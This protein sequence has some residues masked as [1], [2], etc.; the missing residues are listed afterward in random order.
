MNCPNCGAPLHLQGRKDSFTCEYCR[1]IYFPEENDDG[2]R[3]LGE[4][5]S[6]LCPVC[7]IPLTHA[8]MEHHRIQYCT[9]CRGTLVEMSVFIVLIDDLRAERGGFAEVQPPPEPQE[10]KRHLRCPHCGRAMDTHFYGGAGNVVM[11]D[12]SWCELNWL[13]AGELL[14]IARATEHIRLNS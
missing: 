12:C 4:N 8:S 2:V 5:S 14:K 9:R 13:D 1:S 10:L 11:D 7:A 3:L 6:L